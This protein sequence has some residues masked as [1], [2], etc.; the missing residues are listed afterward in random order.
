MVLPLQFIPKKNVINAFPI[1]PVAC[2]IDLK[3]REEL[4]GDGPKFA[5]RQEP[6]ELRGIEKR[7]IKIPKKLRFFWE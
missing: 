2:K 1:F 4:P 3:A 6:S 5:N 7:L